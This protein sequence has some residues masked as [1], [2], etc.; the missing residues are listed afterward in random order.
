MRVRPQDIDPELRARA[1]FLRFVSAP[2][3]SEADLRRPQ[4]LR[5]LTRLMRPPRGVY[6]DERWVAR[7]DGSMLRLR[8]YSPAV[9]RPEAPGMVWLHGGGYVLGSPEQDGASYERIIEAI[10]AVIVAPDYRLAPVAPYPAALD[11][12]YLA[13]CWLRDNAAALGVRDDQ[14]AVAG[15]SAGGG[16]AAALTLL[17]R[18]RGDVAIAFQMPL[19]PMLDDRCATESAC[20][21]DAPVWDAVTNRNAWRVYLGELAGTD[22]VPAFAAPARAVDLRGLPPAFTYVGGV[23]PFR[24]EV[25]DYVARLRAAGVETAFEVYAGCYHGFDVVAPGAAVSRRALASQ[26]AW[27][28]MAAERYVAPQPVRYAAPDATDSLARG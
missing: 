23:E 27:L 8:V 3:R 21:N 5:I 20:E 9:P 25:V 4:R 12:A 14:L 15:N 24:D 22:R 17:A 2:N 6:A 13:L 26:A 19:Y 1:R 18:D 10:G 28:R 11:D 16:L 7:P